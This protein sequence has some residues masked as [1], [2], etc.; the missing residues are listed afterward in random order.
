MLAGEEQRER[1]IQNLK[2]TPV[3]AVSTETD[4]GLEH[5]NCEIMT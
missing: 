3:L 4:W 1:E 5:M 2:Q